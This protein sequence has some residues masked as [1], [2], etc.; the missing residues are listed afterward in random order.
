ML[1]TRTGRIDAIPIQYAIP[2][3]DMRWLLQHDLRDP[4]K[5]ARYEQLIER[6]PNSHRI[7]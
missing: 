2:E 5:L 4:A 7:K 6:W 3:G 1:N